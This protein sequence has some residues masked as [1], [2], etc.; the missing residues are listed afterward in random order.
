MPDAWAPE[1]TRLWRKARRIVAAMLLGPPT[2]TPA[3]PPPL[4]AW[5]A[6]LF[7]A[8]VLGTVSAYV[9]AMLAK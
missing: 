4:A 8:W 3:E 2:P 9:W 6:W 1:K 7:A 5:K